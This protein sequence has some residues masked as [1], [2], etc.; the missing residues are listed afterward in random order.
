MLRPASRLPLAL[1]V[2][3]TAFLAVMVPV[4]WYN[5]GPSNF[6]YFCDISLLLCLISVWTEKALPASMAAVG[7]LL[8]QVL[9][10][11]D[12]VGELLGVRLLGM[13]SYMFDE[14]RSLFLRGLSFFHG[15]LPFLLVYLVRRLGYDRRALWAWT[16]VAWALCLVAYFLLP[17][18]GAIMSDPKIPVNINYVFGF[19]D[20]APQT[21]LPAPVY[22][23]CW[24]LALLVVAYLPTHFVLRRWSVRRPAQPAPLQLVVAGMQEVR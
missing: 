11:A 3:F 15:W 2:L 14:N 7:I 5:Y 16:G 23:V 22:L 9:W 12:F 6:L 17:P 24:M 19:N 10:C 18:A 13:T 20:A 4:Y 21:W 8:P 1:K